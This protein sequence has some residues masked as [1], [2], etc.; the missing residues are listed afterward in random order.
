MK[1][2]N[3]VYSPLSAR[4]RYEVW[5]LRLGLADGSGAWWFRYLL[6]NPGRNANRNDDAGALPVQVWA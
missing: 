4:R 2:L 5:F 1:T 6:M 3:E